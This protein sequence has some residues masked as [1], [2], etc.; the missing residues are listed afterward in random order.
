MYATGP[1]IAR[2]KPTD[3]YPGV[4]YNGTPDKAV[5]GVKESSGR[6]GVCAHTNQGNT[7]DLAWWSVDLGDEYR[8]TGIKIFNRD[9]KRKLKD[10][11]VSNVIQCNFKFCLFLIPQTCHEVV[12]CARRCGGVMKLKTGT[13]MICR[14]SVSQLGLLHT[15]LSIILVFKEL[16]HF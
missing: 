4:F 5:D 14:Q 3:Q 6:G 8:V 12:Y 15:F 7:T 1:N 13:L 16:N 10:T 11:Y 2:G 9:K